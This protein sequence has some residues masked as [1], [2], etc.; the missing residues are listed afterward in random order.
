MTV[1]SPSNV[2]YGENSPIACGSPDHA[3]YPAP[4]TDYLIL[5]IPSIVNYEQTDLNPDVK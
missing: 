2:T 5:K 4:P 3:E 1:L